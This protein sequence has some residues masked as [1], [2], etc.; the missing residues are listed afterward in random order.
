MT[1]A[2]GERRTCAAV[3]A[4]G[5][6][7]RM[8]PGIGA[9]FCYT[10]SPERAA[11]RTAARVRGGEATAG[12]RYFEAPAEPAQLRA[13]EAAQVLIEGTIH[14]IQRGGDPSRARAIF[15]GLRLALVALELGELEA[16]LTALEE[17]L[18]AND[19]RA[20]RRQLSITR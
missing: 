2:R 19:P 5:A 4:S 15:A 11:E 10:H 1:G 12:P 20:A 13:V 18:G 6:P 9:D 14:A 3:T 16:R 8:A 7:C 17:R